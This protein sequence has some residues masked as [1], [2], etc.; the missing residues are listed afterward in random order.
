MNTSQTSGP[1]ADILIVDDTPDNLRLLSAML[2]ENGYKVR[3]AINGER[4]LQAVHAVAPDLILLDVMMPDMRGYEVCYYLKESAATRDIPV[5]FISALDDVFDKVLAFDVGGVDYITKPFHVQEVLAR[6]KTHLNLR[7]FQQQLQSQNNQLQEEI[8]ERKALQSALEILNQELEKKVNERTAEL[9][10]ANNQL[11]KLQT[12][13]R[14]ALATEQELNQLKDEFLKNISHELR[15][16]LNGIIGSLRLVLDDM[17]E[18]PEEELELLQQADGAAIQLLNAIED[19]LDFANLKTGQTIVEI[20]PVDLHACLEEIIAS[21]LTEIKQKHL[22]LVR[23]Y[24][25]ESISVQADPAKLKQV[26]G[27]LLDNA[28]KFTD[29]GSIIIST[30]VQKEANSNEKPETQTAVVQ[31]QDT[32]IGIEKELQHKLFREFV[33]V[34]GSSTRRHSG[35]GLG[36]VISQKLMEL[37]GGSIT[38]ASAGKNQ[39]TT[40]AIALP[41]YA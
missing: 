10:N 6:V 28:I 23:Q 40:V 27:H 29:A 19:V 21:H 30:F 31:I 11:L 2:L 17:C 24:F 1:S 5:I 39:G 13:L 22:Q 33:M 18:S 4:A 34:D 37:M 7:K 26:F 32:G 12:E 3:K 8:D 38:L 16:P 35:N 9:Q 15:T 14:Q 36:L 41:V 20:Q 25:G